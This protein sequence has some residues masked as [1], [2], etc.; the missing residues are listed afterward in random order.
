M[1]FRDLAVAAGVAGAGTFLYGMLYEA[2]R[3]VVDRYRLKLKNWPKRLDG[4]RIAVIGDLHIR[5]EHSAQLAAE[6]VARAIEEDPDMIAI[7]GD[8]VA[9]WHSGIPKLL[10]DVLEPL[11]LMDGRV[12]AIPGNHEYDLGNPEPLKMILD[13]LNVK[14]LRNE[15]WVNQGIS[16][17]GIDSFNE[18]MAE[19]AKAMAEIKESPAI[20]LW[21]ECDAVDFLPSGCQLMIA[22]HSHGGQFTFPGGFTPMHSFMGKKY[23]RG[24][25]ANAPTPLFTTR[26][27]GTTGWPSRLNCPPEVAILELVPA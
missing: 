14:L 4:F 17:V 24:F 13:E 10:G 15:V 19:P 1:R 21:H 20:C 12:V 11:L 18:G 22:G 26:G 6:A 2:D 8:F 23:P 27:V 25:Y 9:Y 16:W 3:L 5:G 7:V